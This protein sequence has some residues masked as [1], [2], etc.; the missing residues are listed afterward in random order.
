MIAFKQFKDSTLIK[1]SI[2]IKDI[3]SQRYID[4]G[5]LVLSEN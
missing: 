2:P 5:Y 1:E 3:H 4:K